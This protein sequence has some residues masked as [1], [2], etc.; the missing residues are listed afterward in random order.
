MGIDQYCIRPSALLGLGQWVNQSILYTRDF[1]FFFQYGI[2]LNSHHAKYI[3][4]YNYIYLFPS[5]ALLSLSLSL[6]YLHSPLNALH[7]LLLLV[8]VVVVIVSLYLNV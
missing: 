8:V 1:K 2:R 3:Y 4:L 6:S 5:H 7:S